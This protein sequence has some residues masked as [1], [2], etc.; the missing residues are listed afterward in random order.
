MFQHSFKHCFL[1]L[2]YKGELNMFGF[3]FFFLLF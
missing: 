2:A 1:L 3:G